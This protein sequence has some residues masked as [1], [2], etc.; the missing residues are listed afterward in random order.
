MTFASNTSGASGVKVRRADEKDAAAIAALGSTTFDQTFG[1]L[2]RD[3]QD[4]EHYLQATFDPQKIERSLGKTNNLYWLA[5]VDDLPVGY[6]KLKLDSPSAFIPSGRTCQ[7]QKIY[8][9]KA[10]L[11]QRIGHRL[12]AQL[13]EKAGQLKYEYIWLS[14]LNSN[15]RAIKFYQKNGFQSIGNHDFQ[16]GKERFS[17]EAMML[18]LTRLKKT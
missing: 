6:A 13:L 1:H 5:F 17:F 12:Q 8:V 2:F 9:E 10:F 7:L 3:P 16:I 4:L 15:E 14:V 18:E 11:K